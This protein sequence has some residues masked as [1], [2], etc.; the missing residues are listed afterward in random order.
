MRLKRYKGD[1]ANGKIFFD[2][3]ES[4]NEGS[5]KVKTLKNG[6]H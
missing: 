3:L 4:C 1:Q 2:E 6:Y 5:V